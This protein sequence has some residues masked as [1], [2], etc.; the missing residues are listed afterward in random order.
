MTTEQIKKLIAAGRTDIFYNSR[1]WRNKAKNIKAAQ[2]N[3][4]QFC[5][6]RGKVGPAD[7]VHHVRH[8]RQYP[9][10]ALSDYYTDEHGNRQRQLVASCFRCHELQ[11]N[12]VFNCKS[13][14]Y[15]NEEKW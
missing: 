11:H 3:E 12:R 1:T 7:L 13:N 9:E 2:N 14:H 15:T 10:L 5:K 6:A 4:C 8:L